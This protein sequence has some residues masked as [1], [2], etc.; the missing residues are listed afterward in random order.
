[1]AQDEGRP[2]TAEKGKGKAVDVNGEKGK[3]SKKDGKPTVDGKIV[4]GL[5]EGY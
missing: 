4:D 2:T 1:M 3:D 5:L